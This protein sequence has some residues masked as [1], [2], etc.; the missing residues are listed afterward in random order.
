V[1]PVGEGWA[2]L[3]ALEQVG[4]VADLQGG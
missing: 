2:R 3:G 4:V 1:R